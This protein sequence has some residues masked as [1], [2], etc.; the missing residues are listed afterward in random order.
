[1]DFMQSWTFM[2]VMLV[3]LIGLIGLFL[4]LRNKGSED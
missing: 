2:L 3:A 4:F 1:M